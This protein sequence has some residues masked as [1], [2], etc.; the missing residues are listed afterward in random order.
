[1]PHTAR[2]L[3]SSA[4]TMTPTKQHLFRSTLTQAFLVGF[5]SFTQPG[6]YAAIANL[7]A[8][9]QA[10]TKTWN[11]STVILNAMAVILGPISALFANRFGLR[12]TLFIGC[13]G[14][15]IY[16]ASLYYNTKTGDQAFIL[17]AS[18]LL[19]ISGAAFWMSEGAIVMSYPEKSRKGLFIGIW[20]MLN[21][22]GGVISGS[23]VFAMNHSGKKKGQ[24]SL[25]TYI[26]LFSIQCTG[27]FFAL[28]LSPPEKVIRNDNT[29]VETNVV[30]DGLEQM[31]KRY[32]GLLRKKEIILLLPILVVNTWYKTWQSNFMTHNFSVRARALNVL[33][34]A[35]IGGVVDVAGGAFLDCQKISVSSRAKISWI[36]I[37][38]FET[39]FYIWGFIVQRNLTH[40]TDALDWS[41]GNYYYDTYVPMQIFK[42]PTEFVFNWVFWVVSVQ[43]FSSEENVYISGLIRAIESFGSMLSFLVGV[44]NSNDMVNLS[45]AASVFWAAVPSVTYLILKIIGT[46]HNNPESVIVQ[47][48][49]GEIVETTAEIQ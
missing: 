35:L 4:L 39:G 41:T 1:M 30:K 45:V 5:L 44:T 6:I 33:L 23:V 12:P 16:S 10:T 19:G 42:I 25:N 17:V 3:P 14:H 28:L 40:S 46:T 13:I 21:K 31:G 20:Q 48:K 38:V 47:N 22:F 32:F 49:S 9:G 11:V 18:V 27:P 34:T 43:E 37:V 8:G 2:K 24:V 36:F 15:T 7:G 26:A 29:R